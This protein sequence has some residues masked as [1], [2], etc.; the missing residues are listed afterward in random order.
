MRRRV[1]LAVGAELQAADLRSA[2]EPRDRLGLADSDA[3][4]QGLGQ[5]AE[6]EVALGVAAGAV[7]EAVAF[8]DELPITGLAAVGEDIGERLVAGEVVLGHRLGERRQRGTPEPAEGIGQDRAAVLSAVAAG[9]EHELEIVAHERQRAGHLLVRQR[10]VAVEVVQVVRA[11]LQEDADRF[12]LGLADPRGVD[13]A[14][15]DVGEAADLREHLAE[16]VGPFPRDG[17]GADRAAAHAA[18]GA[19]VGVVG[20]LDGVLLRDEGQQLVDEELG[21]GAAERIVLE[22]AVA[23]VRAAHAGVDEDADGHRHLSLGDEVVEDDG[24]ALLAGLADVAAAVLEDHERGRLGAVVLRRDVDPA[25]AR[26]L[27]EDLR[28][29]EGE[30]LDPALRHARGAFERIG[31]EL[32]F[33]GDDGER[34]AQ[35]E[36]GEEKWLHGPKVAQKEAGLKLEIEAVRLGGALPSDTRRFANRRRPSPDPHSTK[37]ALNAHDR[38]AMPPSLHPILILCLRL[39]RLKDIRHTC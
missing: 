15:A 25:I 16:L 39:G 5:V 35:Q 34:W 18:D 1:E 9:A 2:F 4:D 7:G 27:G 23:A 14:A 6:V 26:G 33:F 8:A 12:A 13:V 3:V 24:D 31:P 10:P 38:K 30:L 28:I 20:E 29:G 19:L 21:V 37:G 32:V 11:V 22:A 17:E 36:T